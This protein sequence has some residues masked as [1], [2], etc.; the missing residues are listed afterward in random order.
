MNLPLFFALVVLPIAVLAQEDIRKRVRPASADLANLTTLIAPGKSYFGVP[1]GATEDEVI[2]LLGPADGF[3]RLQGKGS[4]LLYGPQKGYLFGD[5]KL[6]GIYLTMSLVDFELGKMMTGEMGMQTPKWRL[7]TG[8]EPEMGRDEV[9]ELL[10]DRFKSGDNYRG[11]YDEGDYRIKLR[12][13][14]YTQEGEDQGAYRLN[15]L[16]VQKR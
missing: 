3:I 14:H 11:H 8:L 7:D 13:S 2:A 16:S 5:G 6:E 4:L 1:A 12:F 9:I 15:S 10:G